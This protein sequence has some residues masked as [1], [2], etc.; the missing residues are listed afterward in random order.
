MRKF[1]DKEIMMDNIELEVCPCCRGNGMLMHEGGWNVQV[2]CADCGS[3][4]VYVEYNNEQEK[5]EAEKMVARLW[6]LGK[7]INANPGE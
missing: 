5:A 6:N 2:E 3:H 4:T 7:V 1:L